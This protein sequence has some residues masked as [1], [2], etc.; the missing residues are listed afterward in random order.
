MEMDEKIIMKYVSNCLDEISPIILGTIKTAYRVGYND[1]YLEGL[2]NNC[3][4]HANN[5]KE[6]A[7]ADGLKDM[8]SHMRKIIL[9]DKYGSFNHDEL[10]D[11]EDTV[12]ASINIH[13]TVINKHATPAI[14]IEINDDDY[15]VVWYSTESKQY[16]IDTWNISDIYTVKGGNKYE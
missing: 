11:E 15:T 8:F 2:G 5:E 9:D 4:A 10:E 1:G 16:H 6:E 7:Y 14:V 3:K 13:D 12:D